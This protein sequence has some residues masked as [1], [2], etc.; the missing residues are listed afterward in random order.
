MK[1]RISINPQEVRPPTIP[2]G[3]PPGRHVPFF[4]RKGPMSSESYHTAPEEP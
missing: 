2:R 3:P 4:G 1:N